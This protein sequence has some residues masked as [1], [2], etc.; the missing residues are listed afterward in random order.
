V[1]FESAGL[2]DEIAE[3][4][5]GLLEVSSPPVAVLLSVG[6]PAVMALVLQAVVMTIDVI[7]APAAA[8]PVRFKNCRLEN[9]ATLNTSPVARVS[10]LLFSGIVNLQIVTVHESST[11]KTSFAMSI[12]LH[13]R[14]FVLQN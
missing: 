7:S 10:L 9:S 8:T 4:E 12:P 13:Y 11:Q 14:R 5:A 6:V 2:D 1:E 3:D